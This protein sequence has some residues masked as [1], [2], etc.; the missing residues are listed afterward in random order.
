[1]AGL[2]L[3]TRY[4]WRAVSGIEQIISETLRISKFYLLLEIAN[5]SHC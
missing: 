3:H 4:T 1:M 5:Q 2:L